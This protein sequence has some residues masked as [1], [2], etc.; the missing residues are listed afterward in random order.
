MC[1]RDRP[2]A[3][4]RGGPRP[5]HGLP[6]HCRRAARPLAPGRRRCSGARARLLVVRRPGGLGPRAQGAHRDADGRRAA[7]GRR[8]GAVG[9]PE[10]AGMIGTI[11]TLAFATQV[12]RIAVP[13][14][15]AALCG[16]ITERSGIVD[17]ALEGKLLFGAFAAAAVAYVTGS[18]LL[19]IAAGMA[20]MPSR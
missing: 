3:C 6:R 12:I 4:L 19:G 10:V 18:A 15:F 1:I 20:A 16:S 14:A 2:Q 13:Y 11:L 17:L 7:R 8:R 5:R 9:Q